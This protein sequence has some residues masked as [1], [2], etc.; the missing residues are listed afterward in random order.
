MRR[1]AGGDMT[2]NVDSYKSEYAALQAKYNEFVQRY[3]MLLATHKSLQK[4]AEV[5][6]NSTLSKAHDALMAKFTKTV[7]THKKAVATQKSN[8]RDSNRNVRKL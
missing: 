2:S 6:K 7:A 4:Q 5:I 8:W 1:S 3:E